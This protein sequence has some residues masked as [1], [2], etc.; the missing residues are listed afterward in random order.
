M[1]LPP[2]SCSVSLLRAVSWAAEMPQA[3][4]SPAKPS[5]TTP[6]WRL[7][8]SVTP[9]ALTHSPGRSSELFFSAAQYMALSISVHELG[10]LGGKSRRRRHHQ[11]LPAARA[12]P[13][14]RI[15]RVCPG[16]LSEGHSQAKCT[17][18]FSISITAASVWELLVHVLQTLLVGA[19]ILQQEESMLLHTWSSSGRRREAR[20]GCQGVIPACC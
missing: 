1:L 4:A 18:L 13:A 2:R 15:L 14:V 19:L 11:H 9:G 17:H 16:P 8:A 20:L 6:G 3:G 7:M 12:I 5:I 10:V